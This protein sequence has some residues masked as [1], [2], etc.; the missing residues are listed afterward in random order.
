MV[1][2]N[3][4]KTLTYFVLI[5]F[6]ITCGCDI[7]AEEPFTITQ[8]D[9]NGSSSCRRPH[10][11]GLYAEGRTF[12]CWAGPEMA[13]CVKMYDHENG[14]WSETAVIHSY[15]NRDYHDYPMM[16]L[17][18]DKY[19]HVFWTRH[20]GEIHHCRSP[21]PLSIKGKWSHQVIKGVRATYPCPMAGPDGTLYLFYR[22]RGNPKRS[23]ADYLKSTDKGKTWQVVKDAIST[24]HEGK[25][26]GFYLQHV[27]REPCPE[28]T[29][30]RYQLVWHLRHGGGNS[31]L[32][33]VYFARFYPDQEVFQSVDGSD[34]G[35]AISH[36]EMVEHCLV[37]ETGEASF[38]MLSQALDNGAPIVFYRLWNNPTTQCARWTGSQWEDKAVPFGPFQDVEKI[39]PKAFRVYVTPTGEADKLSLWETI[40]GGKTWEH[41]GGIGLPTKGISQAILINNFHPAAKLFIKQDDQWNSKSYSGEDK[42]FV[43]GEKELKGEP[44]KE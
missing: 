34:L 28:G 42:I 20:N 10:N 17:G 9:D 41:T 13:P 1:A 37:K 40:D 39:G 27:T 38:K 29:T 30:W 4:H 8:I 12:V 3:S 35:E 44:M 7:L 23:H 26:S 6:I 11:A 36:E 16:I 15:R 14:T 22:G 2:I 25:N 18:P 32:K 24:K 5:M 31:P 21:E 43:A 19:L 33:N